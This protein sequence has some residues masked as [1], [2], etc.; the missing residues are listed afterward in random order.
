MREAHLFAIL[1]LDWRRLRRGFATLGIVGGAA[2]SFMA[3]TGR[4]DPENVIAIA[5]GGGISVLFGV[6]LLGLRD[7]LEGTLSLLAS[8]PVSAGS[9]AA[10]RLVS[11]VILTLPVALI[12][13]GM[14][15]FAAAGIH[16]A[17]QQLAVLAVVIWIGLASG[18]VWLAAISIAVPPQR[19]STTMTIMAFA[20][21]FLLTPLE[22]MYPDARSL[23]MALMNPANA[24]VWPLVLL[25]LI[26]VSAVGAWALTAWGIRNYTMEAERPT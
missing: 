4:A 26:A 2:L 13:C 9:L 20:G 14:A 17:I 16:T 18:V 23:V 7:R 11:L 8:L 10:S 15:G 25:A 3:A 19:A 5:L 22:S 12:V 21:Y 24:W 1:A 6:A